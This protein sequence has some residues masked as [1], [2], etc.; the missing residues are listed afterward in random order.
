MKEDSFHPFHHHLGNQG[1]QCSITIHCACDN[2]EK[3]SSAGNQWCLS[4]DCDV[5]L[6]GIKDKDDF[7]TAHTVKKVIVMAS[8][9]LWSPDKWHGTKPEVHVWNYCMQ[10]VLVDSSVSKQCRAAASCF[11]ASVKL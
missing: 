3:H 2:T 4:L 1:M 6:Y 5:M 9:P 11:R 8:T 7:H 10:Q